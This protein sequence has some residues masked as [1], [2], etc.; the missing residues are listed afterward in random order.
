MRVLSSADHR[1][2]PPI[3]TIPRRYGP[4]DES[5]GAA[6]PEE[7]SGLYVA[8][9]EVEAG[10]ITRGAVLEAPVVG[11]D[12]AEYSTSARIDALRRNAVSAAG[13]RYRCPQSRLLRFSRT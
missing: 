12:D 5:P 11:R 13:R 1:A 6:L 7:V 9:V 3:V 2:I 4:A 8:P 10:P